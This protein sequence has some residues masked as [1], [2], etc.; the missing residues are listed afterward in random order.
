MSLSEMCVNENKVWETDLMTAFHC[1]DENGIIKTVMRYRIPLHAESEAIYLSKYDMAAEDRLAFYKNVVS[2]IQQQVAVSQYLQDAGVSSVLSFLSMEQERD[3]KGVSTIYLATEQVW[4]ILDK[5]LVDRSDVLTLLDVI[6]RLGTVLKNINKEGIGVVHRGLDLRNV[7]INA[8]NRIRLGGFF[9]A[10]CPIK[11][12][13]PSYLPGSPSPLDAVYSKGETGNETADIRTLS[14]IAWNLF[15]GLPH[16]TQIDTSRV[17]FP[18]YATEELAQLLWDGMSGSFESCN[19][20]RRRLLNY[21]NQ[22]KDTDYAKQM[23]PIRGQ[24]LKTFSVGFV[25]SQSEI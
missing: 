20:F 11:S 7:Y 13:V 19:S 22:I 14:M 9:Y 25:N 10:Y 17:V 4:P 12:G 16:N 3:K 6:Y 2:C 24:Q 15:S 18:Q 5:L 8:E 21:R 23:I 1:P